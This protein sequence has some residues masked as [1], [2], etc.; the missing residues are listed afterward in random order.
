VLTVDDL[1]KEV[2]VSRA[3]AYR[4]IQQREIPSYRIG[5]CV[6]VKERDV[7]RYLEKAR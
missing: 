1:A 2:N 7:A 6:R 4:F 3:F 5:W